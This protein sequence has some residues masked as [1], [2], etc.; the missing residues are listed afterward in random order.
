MHLERLL[1]FANVSNGIEVFEELEIVMKGTQYTLAYM[2]PTNTI[3]DLSCNNLV[4]EIPTSIG[5]MSH[6]T[7]L[8]LS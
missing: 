5:S 6:L 3:F 4:G 7:L 2:S 1:G 8:N